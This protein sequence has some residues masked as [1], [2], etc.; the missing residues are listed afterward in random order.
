MRRI[1]L[2]LLCGLFCRSGFLPGEDL[3][4]VRFDRDIRPILSKHCFHCH[5]PDHESREA[6]LRL[7]TKEGLF[8]K[9]ADDHLAVVSDKPEESG[10]YERVSTDDASLKMPPV[11]GGK[12]LSPEQIDL[13]KRW[14]AEGA[15]WRGHWGYEPI[16][17]PKVPEVDDREWNT[18][19]IDRFVFQ[20]LK[21]EGVTPV[22]RADSVTLLRRLSLDLTGLIPGEE[23]ATEFGDLNSAEV[24]QRLVTKLL[25]SP[26]YGERMAVYWLDLVRYADSCGYHSDVEQNVS[27]YRDYVINAFNRNLK[28]D[29]FTREQL[30][31]DL[32]PN[33]TVDQ[34]VATCLNRLNK[35]TEEGGAQEGEYLAKAFADRVRTVSVTWLGA[36]FGC[37]ECHDHKF[38]PITTRDF[39]SFG[40]FFAD[41][42]E[43][44]VYSPRD[45]HA[46]DLALPTPEQTER[47]EKLK[48]EL[49]KLQE[50][51]K[52]LSPEPPKEKVAQNETVAGGAESA[53]KPDLESK[54]DETKPAEAGDRKKEL[55]AE[56][57]RVDGELKKLEGEI[58]R[59]LVTVARVPREIRVLPRGD[60]LNKT[61]EVV[62]AAIPATF[63]S[64]A[65]P[66]RRLTRMDLADWLMDRK[67]P[68]TARVFVNRVWKMLFGQG[69]SRNL[70]DLGFQGEPPTHPELIDGL[71]VEF[72]ESGWDIKH[73]IRVIVSSRAYQM[74]SVPGPGMQ[75]R[76]PQN[77][78]LSHQSRWR[79][80]A[81]F[82]RDNALS[83][84]GLLVK[85][86]GGPSVKPYQ[87]EKYWE[88]LNFP[89]RDW[90]ASTGEDQYRR[91]L[92]THWQRTFLHPSLLA[93]DAS[94]REECVANRPTSNTPRAALAL[95]NDPTFVEAARVF[96]VHACEQK[97][98]GD[99]ARL[100]WCWKKALTREPEKQELDA[101]KA[102]LQS[103]REEYKSNEESAKQLVSV[104]LAAQPEGLSASE[105]AAWTMVCRSILNL[106]EFTT[107]N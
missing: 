72:M 101:L 15:E 3:P 77:R 95:L 74:S 89:T 4:K 46:P 70:E 39:Y 103:C 26:Q 25:D 53:T 86:I 91:G 78:L 14:I 61:G 99:E 73:L 32:L 88:F 90:I 62:E 48:G 57:A 5:G 28:F 71:A 1:F 44:G 49:A 23:M 102:L 96:A 54:P 16:V 19:E 81:E 79:L 52:G 105:A 24:Y 67:N 2:C 58:R 55:E 93:F 75:D 13:L 27:P 29:Q 8:A 9:L 107:R 80:E 22:K 10:L 85:R 6:D 106:H 21:S 104:G 64:D 41:V 37:A 92:Y 68:L 66:E 50:E 11:D 56:I 87:P 63:A 17:R 47:Q 82:L 18:T 35:S 30:A 83:V 76:D 59:V 33:P 20:Q 100:R 36:T 97:F 69:L 31:G 42:S 40:A 98:E 65:N 43:K 34:Q 84:S 12:P 94:S 7:D 51:L 45:G 60:W 38:D